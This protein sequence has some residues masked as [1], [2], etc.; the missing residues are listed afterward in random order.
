MSCVET[1]YQVDF[2]LQAGAVMASP[3][4]LA[5]GAFCVT[6]ITSLSFSSRSW[7][8]LSSR[9]CAAPR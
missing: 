9:A 4:V 8:K 5:S 7:Q 6:A 3:K 1:W 2:F